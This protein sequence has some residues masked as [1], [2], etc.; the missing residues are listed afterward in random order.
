MVTRMNKNNVKEVG[1]DAFLGM[2]WEEVRYKVPKG[3]FRVVLIGMFDHTATIIQDFDD[4]S[5]AKKYV[6]NNENML[7]DY[8]SMVIYNDKGDLVYDSDWEKEK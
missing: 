5:S 1:A 2:G 6:L 4:E 8:E 7:G 3:K